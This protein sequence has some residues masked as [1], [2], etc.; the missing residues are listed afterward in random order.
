MN[1]NG[2]LSTGTVPDALRERGVT[3]GPAGAQRPPRTGMERTASWMV[4]D[5]LSCVLHLS[6]GSLAYLMADQGHDVVIA[7]DDVTSVRH[8]EI[9]YVR[10]QGERLPFRP[11]AFDVVVV[12]EL[13]DSPTALAEYA[14][15]LRPDGLLSTVTR[16]YDDSIP[17][18]RKLREI[19]GD[20]AP[21]HTPADTFTASGLFAEPES[22]EF[23]TWEQLDLAGFMR[24]AES[25]KDAR[26]DDDALA[27][28]GA[29]FASYGGQT[30]TLRLRHQ[31]RCLRAR[32][33]KE[34]L[35]Q[36]APPPE[37]T[38]IALG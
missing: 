7:G 2:I 24:F 9:Q 20:R 12:S 19:I 35:S 10:T 5:T 4:G 14:R 37:A 18:I 21:R 31:T 33:L 30:G 34:N 13:R 32:V 3:D 38:L 27:R 26:A 36:E 29:L 1:T 8:P 16:T 17:W 15:V 22:D 11:D 25:T 28:V 23:A 6:D